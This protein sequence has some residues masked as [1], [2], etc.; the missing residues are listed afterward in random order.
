M[1]AAYNIGVIDMFIVT[2]V[3]KPIIS[4]NEYKNPFGETL[5]KLG[6]ICEIKFNEMVVRVYKNNF[7]AR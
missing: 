1:M 3:N 2:T 6:A 5:A 4:V 7:Q